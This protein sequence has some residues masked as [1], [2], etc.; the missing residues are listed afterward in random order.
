MRE[1]DDLAEPH[2]SMVRS[3]DVREGW[4]GRQGQSSS[5]G[6][7]HPATRYFRCDLLH[8]LW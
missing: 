7:E 5:V 2:W 3:G 4:A 1:I 6:T 8:R